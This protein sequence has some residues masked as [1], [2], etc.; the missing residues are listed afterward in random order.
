MTVAC[1]LIP[2]FALRVAAGRSWQADRPA[3]LAPVPG[4]RQVVGETSRPAEM[5]GV[6]AGMAL[7][8]ALSRCPSL[9]LVTPDPAQAAELWEQILRRLE[10]IGAAVESTSEGEAFFVV[11]G[12]TGLHGGEVDGVLRAAGEAIA[13]RALLGAAPGRFAAALAAGR[14]RQL[15]RGVGDVDGV[16][17]DRV[18]FPFLRP[19]PVST[20]RG[21][22][23]PG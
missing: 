17:S 22:I 8:E 9:R 21:R 4:S 18:L 11:D 15:P 5:L 23:D 13:T 7:G 6:H 14:R 2:R 12:L 10:G 3:A 19:H 1:V 20:L 16:I